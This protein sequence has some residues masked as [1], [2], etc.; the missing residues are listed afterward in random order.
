MVMYSEISKAVAGIAKTF[1]KTLK[2][3]L[4]D[5]TF[6]I[7]K[8]AER[9]LDA[10]NIPPGASFS[11]WVQLFSESNLVHENDR[12]VFFSRLTLG[13]IRN[14]LKDEDSLRVQYRRKIKDEYRWVSLEIIKT[15]SYSDENQEIWLFVRDIHGDHI[16]EMEIQREL[17]HYC[18][19]DSLTGLNNYYSYQILCKNF[20]LAEKKASIG[21]IFADLNG[22]KLINDTRGHGAGNEFL[23]SFARKL[24]EHF[25]SEYIYR[26]SGD[27]FFVVMSGCNEKEFLFAAKKIESSLNQ[28]T[29][30]QAAVGFCWMAHPARIEDV[31]RVAEIQM[32]KNKEA[33][34]AK[35]PE[36]KRGIAEINYKREMDAILKTL[37]NSYDCIVTI[38]LLRDSFWVLKNTHDENFGQGIDSY[39]QL[40]KAFTQSVDPEY[41][42]IVSSVNGI[43]NL[44]LELQKKTSIDTESKM[45]DGRW[46]RS[47]FKAI[48]T[49]NGEPT[50]A[51]L[52]VERLDHDRILQLEKTRDLMLEHQIIEGLSKGFSLI[53]QVDVPAKN[54]LVYKNISLK[55]AVP[56]AIRSLSYD[57]VINWFVNK[58]VVADDRERTAHALRLESVMEKLKNRDVTTILCRT[59]PEFHDTKNV[60]YSM[61][62]FYKLNTTPNKLV[63]ATKNVT[64][65]MG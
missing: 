40:T 46:L 35:H 30:P 41:Q 14:H 62:F 15:E 16:H 43:S 28:E 2:V 25:P 49:M 61:F 8:F 5:N 55:D 39:S 31:A 3:N 19:F 23:Q 21:L 20:T 4:T 58:Y 9:E 57:G 60:S 45:N 47:T 13:S 50:K 65:S 33:F 26:I 6:V 56:A 36:Y 34:Y 22:L 54:I 51:L 10:L 38:D 11:D 17:E 48:E 63:L 37:A 42:D 29:V 53:C 24:L 32:Y 18:K 12:K 64:N 59:T 44:R 52:I 7:V 1:Y 27:E